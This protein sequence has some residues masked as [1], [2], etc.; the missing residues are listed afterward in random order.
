MISKKLSAVAAA[1]LLL[2]P[3][4]AHALVSTIIN[5]A[6]IAQGSF[7]D[8]A[9]DQ[10]SALTSNTHDILAVGTAEGA[11]SDWLHQ[12]PLGG[13]DGFIAALNYS[14]KLDWSLRLGGAND[15][16]AT[17]ATLSASGDIWVAGVSAPQSELT[18]LTIWQIAATGT[19]INTFHTSAPTIIYPHSITE[20]GGN[21]LV[22]GMDFSITLKKSGTFTSLKKIT[23]SAP[24][25]AAK[26]AGSKYSWNIYTGRGPV[27]GIPTF[28]PKRSS[29]L[30]YKYLN[31]TKSV[32]AAYQIAENPLL[33]RYQKDFGIILVS[34]S[35]SGFS[36]YLLK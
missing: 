2:L 20:V 31:T 29:T 28:K 18:E 27:A 11:N 1:I 33:L 23:F 25:P 5:A 3:S 8:G 35:E 7:T 12:E 36:F 9:G 14:G 10:V 32:R 15:D 6:P 21:F 24:K 34:E 17:A 22:Q 30:Y 26:Y 16:I 13:S 4:S 19:L